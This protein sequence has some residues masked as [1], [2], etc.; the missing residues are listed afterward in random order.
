MNRREN[1]IE[2]TLMRIIRMT[3][4]QVYKLLHTKNDITVTSML[5]CLNTCECFLTSTFNIFKG[6][7]VNCSNT[8]IKSMTWNKP[9]SEIT[10]IYKQ[11]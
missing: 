8:L 9:V 1:E 10:F 5:L 11:I 6:S 3:Q 2:V 7:N 4:A